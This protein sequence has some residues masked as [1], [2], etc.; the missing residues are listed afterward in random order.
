MQK[1]FIRTLAALV[2]LAAIGLVGCQTVVIEVTATLPA[3]AT[4]DINLAVEQTVAAAFNET[5]TAQAQPQST[6]VPA[7][8]N[9]VGPL[10]GNVV[11]AQASFEATVFAPSPTARPTIAAPQPRA[12]MEP[13]PTGEVFAAGLPTSYSLAP[14]L[15]EVFPDAQPNPLVVYGAESYPVGT[16]SF[17]LDYNHYTVISGG[18][19]SSYE[20]GVDCTTTC[21]TI[22]FN[23][24]ARSPEFS[25]NLGGAPFVLTGN[26]FGNVDAQTAML[27]LVEW[28]SQKLTENNDA[29]SVEVHLIR[30]ETDSI[31]NDWYGTFI[32]T[33]SSS[34]S[35]N[36]ILSGQG[37]GAFAQTTVDWS[38]PIPA[39]GTTVSLDTV[40]K[41]NW[42]EGRITYQK[43]E[44][45]CTKDH[46]VDSTEKS[47]TTDAYQEGCV[48]NCDYVAYGNV[49]LE[50]NQC[51]RFSGDSAVLMPRG[52]TMP[53]FPDPTGRTNWGLVCNVT[54]TPLLFTFSGPFGSD[55]TH[56][57]IEGILTPAMVAHFESLGAL[58]FHNPQQTQFGTTFVTAE[59]PTTAT[60][61]PNC[62]QLQNGCSGSDMTTVIFTDSGPVIPLYGY[63]DET[64]NG[65]TFYPMEIPVLNWEYPNG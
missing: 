58:Q 49:T 21:L 52:N 50:Y 65:G 22:V 19:Q 62:G 56:Y 14:T 6:L 20:L 47:C 3:T 5:A 38:Q 17:T 60:P 46:S 41:Q 44:T 39:P 25:V 30:V 28:Y 64:V 34:L 63:R 57:Q 55:R 53:L 37:G 29:P 23:Q 31:T 45:E 15:R 18:Q 33:N 2:L 13:S 59:V 61:S 54:Q 36:D 40:L 16:T 24:G 26:V 27:A 7:E 10:G 48:Q 4:T 32:P 8:S 35:L 9:Q 42:P 11:A 12:T 43:P 51:F 1:N